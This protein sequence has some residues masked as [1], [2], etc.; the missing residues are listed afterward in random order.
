MPKMLNINSKSKETMPKN[1]KTTLVE[2]PRV[3]KSDFPDEML[4]SKNKGN[5]RNN[6]R[7]LTKFNAVKHIYNDCL[8]GMTESMIVNK[9]VDDFYDIGKKYSQAYAYTLLAEVKAMIRDDMEKEIQDI[10]INLMAKAYD[11]YADAREHGDRSNAM[12][13]LNF[14][15]KITGAL[16][17]RYGQ[18]NVQNIIIDFHFDDDDD[19]KNKLE[20]IEDV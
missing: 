3:K 18:T 13:A 17:P 2:K 7:E 14:I 5:R 1:V 20:D 15:S 9:L 10:R 16:D 11:T 6:I 12:S 19:N 8:L 4:P